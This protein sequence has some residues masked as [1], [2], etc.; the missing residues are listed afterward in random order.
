V[1]RAGTYGLIGRIVFVLALL[2]GPALAD[3]AIEG[4]VAVVRDVDTIVV[5]GTPVRLNGLDGPETAI[6]IGREARAFTTR[7]VRG[8]TVACLLNGDWW[9]SFFFEEKHLAYFPGLSLECN[10]ALEPGCNGDSYGVARMGS[11][12][13]HR[14]KAAKSRS[15]RTGGRPP[16][17]TLQRGARLWRHFDE[18]L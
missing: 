3:R 15:L 1:E 6:R 17:R 7:L 8:E 10:G 16:F 5:A 13:S 9:L 4:R 12:G 2:I 14:R 11:V 18:G